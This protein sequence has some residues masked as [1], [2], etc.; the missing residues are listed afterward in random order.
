MNIDLSKITKADLDQIIKEEV[1]K[2]KAEMLSESKL[3]PQ[4]LKLMLE[5][6]KLEN[7]L[8]QLSESP[9]LEEGI[10]GRMFGGGNKDGAEKQTVLNLLKHPQK[11]VVLLTYASPEQLARFKSYM[12][13]DKQDY[14]DWAIKKYIGPKKVNDPKR[15]ESYIKFFM[16]GGNNPVWDAASHQYS[17]AGRVGGTAATAFG[18]SDLPQA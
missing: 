4:Q 6:R 7:E 14:I 11:S 1:L 16:D 9:D 18:E 8:K 10:L 13:P 2:I 15:A 17:D 12:A 5:K 3:D